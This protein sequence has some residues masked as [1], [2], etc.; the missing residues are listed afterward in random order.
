VAKASKKHQLKDEEF[1]KLIGDRIR[2]YREAKGWT[3]TE[4]AVACKDDL[5]YS[6]ISRMERGIVNFSITYL[7]AV[8]DALNINI[9]SHI[10]F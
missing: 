9:K 3:Q 10:I 5:D 8:A 2:F 1:L 7:K 4:L 6:Q